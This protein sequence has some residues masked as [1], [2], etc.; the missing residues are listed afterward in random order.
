MPGSVPSSKTK[1]C[2]VSIY[3]FILNASLRMPSSQP[4]SL[5]PVGTDLVSPL[6]VSLRSLSHR[7][8]CKH[9]LVD[10]FILFFQMGLLYAL[11]YSSSLILPISLTAQNLEPRP[12][13]AQM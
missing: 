8:A 2:I 12:S 4:E 7:Y 11:L 13:R 3:L 10:L 5:L 6:A 9:F 1:L